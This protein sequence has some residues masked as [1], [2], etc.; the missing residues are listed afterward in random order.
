MTVFLKA[1]VLISAAT[2]LVIRLLTSKYVLSWD[3]DLIST[4]NT[5]A[6]ISSGIL[7]VSGIAWALIEKKKTPKT[8]QLEKQEE[9]N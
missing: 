7:L 2:T 1:V 4:L 5:V 8:E 9:E 6:Y 3:A